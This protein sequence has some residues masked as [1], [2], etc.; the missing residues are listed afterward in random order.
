MSDQNTLMTTFGVASVADGTAMAAAQHVTGDLVDHRGRADMPAYAIMAESVTSGTFWYSFDEAVGT[1]QSWLSLTAG[2]PVKVDDR[3]SASSELLYS[4]GE[5]GA[6]SLR[7]V[8]DSHDLVCAGLAR[9]VLVGRSGDSLADIK[10]AM[11]VKTDGFE[12]EVHPT[13]AMPAP[14]DASLDGASILAGIGDGRISAGPLC[15]LLSATVT[16]T[17]EQIR[18]RVT[19]QEWMIN[20]IGGIQG[21]VMAT[22]IGQACSFAGQLP[23]APGQQYSMADLSVYFFRSPP[24]GTAVTISA[25]PDRVGRRL[26][27]VSASMTNDDGVEFARATADIRF[28]TAKE[29]I[30]YQQT[31]R[32]SRVNPTHR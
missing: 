17:G 13:A 18:M 8:N 26:G 12:P 20:P 10:N 32:G 29:D 25:A 24:F 22:M 14:I 30:R 11:P 23:T 15:E 9:C 16:S 27:T 19:P 5:H 4:D 28:A 1:V 7:I 3:L 2:A 6:V 21:G 31:G